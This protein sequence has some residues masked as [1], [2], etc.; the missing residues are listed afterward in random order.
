MPQSEPS[1]F[2]TLGGADA[3][4][5]FVSRLR[6]HFGDKGQIARD[7]PQDP[8]PLLMRVPGLWWF[9]D[10]SGLGPCGGA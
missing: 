3:Q 2:A 9:L 8:G 4:F 7:R 5:L 10:A 6:A 1:W